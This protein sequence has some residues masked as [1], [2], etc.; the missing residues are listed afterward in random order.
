MSLR[1]VDKL[2]RE[3][4]YE[5]A[6]KVLLEVRSSQ[7]NNPYLPAYEERL[8]SAIEVRSRSLEEA[9]QDAGSNLGAREDLSIEFPTVEEQLRAIARAVPRAAEP[10]V[11]KRAIEQRKREE[12]RRVALLS[13]IASLIGRANEFLEKGEFDRALEEVARATMLDPKNGDIADL[14]RRIRSS[15]E[16]ALRV[17][18]EQRRLILQQ[19]EAEREQRL[20]R[21]REEELRESEARRAREEKARRAAQEEKVTLCLRRSREFLN[22]GLLDEAQTEL[23][24]AL[25]L[26]PHN[27]EASTLERE[28]TRRYEQRRQAELAREREESRRDID[29]ANV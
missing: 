4:K 13:K 25:V 19:E 24:F 17:A 22:S 10:K 29:S 7:P 12:Q 3:E 9:E 28:L 1:R 5:Q 16:E 15:Q 8:R 20:R 23:A 26:Q 21:E 18:E 14:E 11:D 27:E 6:L 2:V